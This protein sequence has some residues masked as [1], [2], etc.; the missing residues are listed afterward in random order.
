MHEW[1]NIYTLLTDST[2]NGCQRTYICL[3]ISN[4]QK[5]MTYTHIR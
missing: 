3:E 2:L 1:V 4:A 5:G